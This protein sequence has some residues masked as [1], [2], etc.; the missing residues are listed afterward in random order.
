MSRTK[1]RNVRV[2]RALFNP[3]PSVGETI[4]GILTKYALGMLSVWGIVS[5]LHVSV[6]FWGILGITVLLFVLAGLAEA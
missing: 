5:I 2:A 1:T 3:G 6:G 4:L